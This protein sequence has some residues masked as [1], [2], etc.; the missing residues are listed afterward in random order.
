MY[1]AMS[2]ACSADYAWKSASSATNAKRSRCDEGR[3]PRQAAL[4]LDTY[5]GGAIELTGTLYRSS[6][7]IEVN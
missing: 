7:E 5:V 1:D 4:E 2:R 6:T 3:E